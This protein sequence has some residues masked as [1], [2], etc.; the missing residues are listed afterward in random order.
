MSYWPSVCL[1]WGN[2]CFGLLPVFLLGCFLAVV[3]LYELFVYILDIK[4][5]LV[6]LLA[7]IFFH[8]VGY[9]FHFVY[10]FLCCAKTFKFD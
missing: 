8:F 9:H 10:C 2:V 6:T 3:G 5:L 4:P 1:L 7:N